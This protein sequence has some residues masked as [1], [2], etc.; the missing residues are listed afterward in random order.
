MAQLN[1]SI[2]LNLITNQFKKGVNDVKY[3][4][5]SIRMQ[6]ATFAAALQ[7]ADM[8]ISGFV[9]KMIETARAMRAK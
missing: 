1:F 7:L 3:S 5:S 2:A 6:V 9:S 4:F 8:S